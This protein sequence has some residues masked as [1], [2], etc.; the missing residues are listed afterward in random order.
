M[1]ALQGDDSPP[2]PGQ[3]QK[4]GQR[5][6]QRLGPLLN[7]GKVMTKDGLALGGV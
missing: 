7:P 6:G 2:G 4:Q 3:L 5:L 1:A